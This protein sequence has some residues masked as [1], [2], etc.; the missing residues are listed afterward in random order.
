MNDAIL[1]RDRLVV[2]G[3]LVIITLLAWAYMVFLAWQMEHMPMDMAMPQMAGWTVT[4]FMLT[5]VMWAVMMVAMMIP[6]AA[7]MIL[8]YANISR[9]RHA[10][11]RPFGPTTIFVLGYVVVWTG[12]S[13]VATFAQW[14]LHSATLLSPMMMTTSVIL[15]SIL[16]IAA[17]LFQFTSMKQRCLQHC[18]TPLSFFLNGWRDGSR[19]AFQMGFKHGA[20]CL[21]CCWALMALLF[22]AGVMNLLWVA[23]LAGLVLL[24]KV[25]PK[26]QI[27]ARGAGVVFLLW[28]VWLVADLAMGTFA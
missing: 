2:V 28:G 10:A 24:E 9:K 6:S 27:V 20:F 19:G 11:Q 26:G 8:T 14:L 13:L 25:L 4:E 23:V 7:P 12:F 21:G 3:G 18:R 1:R 5:F 22:V 17:G 15:G 16:L